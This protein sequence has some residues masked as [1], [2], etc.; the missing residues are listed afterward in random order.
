MTAITTS[1]ITNEKVKE[2][3]EILIASLSK[4]R[5]DLRGQQS[6]F[7]REYGADPSK[8]SRVLSGKLYDPTMIEA[9][10]VFR[11]RNM[12]LERNTIASLAE[13]I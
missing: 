11:D 9:M 12:E 2:Q 3:L 13:R 4:L 1:A 8:V 6:A 5:N 10:I 7:A